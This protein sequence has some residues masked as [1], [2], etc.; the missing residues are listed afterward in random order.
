VLLLPDSVEVL[1]QAAVDLD[2]DGAEEQVFL[3]GFGGAPERLGYDFLQMFVIAAD[4][5]GGYAIAWQSEQLPTER[6]EPLQVQDVNGDSLPEV[7]SVQGMGASGEVLYLL[8]WQGD[9]YGWLTPQGGR[10]DGSDS[11][12]ENGVRVEDVDGDGLAEI[13]ASYGPAAGSTD[14][15]AWD[16]EAYVYQETVGDAGGAYERVPVA[17]AGL[18]LEVPA[19]WTQVDATTWISPEDEDLCL[20]VAW[21]DLEAPQEVEAVMLPQPALVLDAEPVELPWGS[22]RRFTVEVYGEAAEGEG[23]APV[24]AVEAH[25]L[26]VVDQGGTRRAFDV[27]AGAPSAEQLAA[28]E[29]VLQRASTSVVFE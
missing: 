8:G 26:V 4:G 17:E 11:F 24:E 9:A 13:L 3:T 14:V 6:A 18:S 10:F 5:S 16:G 12:G 22:G 15:Y 28:L 19:D 2:G 7:V 27:Y 25:V 21:A 20:G 29:P 23:Q 1:S